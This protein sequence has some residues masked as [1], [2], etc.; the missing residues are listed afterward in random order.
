[1][2]IF[3]VPVI[4]VIGNKNS[5]KTLT[6]ETLTRALSNQGYRVATVKHIPEAGF[7][8]DTEGTDTWR[9]ARAGA[10]VVLSVAPNE[11]AIIKRAETSDYNL[12]RII[13]EIG[14]DVDLVILEGFRNLA[15][16]EHSV[17]KIIAVQTTNEIEEA[18]KSYRSILAFVGQIPFHNVEVPVPFINIS[19]EKEKLI[20]LV[21]RKLEAFRDRH[22]RILAKKG[23]T[24]Q[25]DGR[26]LLL[27]RFVQ[28]I[29]KRTILSMV[30]TLKDVEIEGDEEVKIIIKK[31]K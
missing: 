16:R 28:E 20:R 30:S 15:K 13:K 24:I 19:K 17:L 12:S 10:K 5:G 7:T 18:R 21:A 9:H 8:I 3:R 31:A 6:V 26:T 27:R 4:A 23:I 11:V 25:V 2:Y 1:M 29:F 14:G 22:S